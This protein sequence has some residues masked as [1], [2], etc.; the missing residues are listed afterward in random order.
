MGP[1]TLKAAAAVTLIESERENVI[2]L[3][4]ALAVLRAGGVRF[5]ARLRGRY[6]V[7]SGWIAWDSKCRLEIN[8]PGE[9]TQAVEFDGEHPLAGRGW[10]AADLAIE[11]GGAEISLQLDGEIVRRVG[12]GRRRDGTNVAAVGREQVD[13]S[14]SAPLNVIVAVYENLEATVACFEALFAEGSAA[15]KRVIAVDDASPNEAIRGWLSCQAARGMLETIRNDVNLGF[16]ASVNRALALCDQGDALLLNADAFLTPGAIDRLAAVA[17]SAEDIGTVTPFSNNGEFTSF[18]EPNVVNAL[19]D[20]RTQRDIAEAAFAAN[21]TEAVDMPNGVGFCLYVTRACLDRVGAMPELYARGYY[22]DVEFCLRARE[23]GLRSVCATG[24]YV[25]HA[26]AQSFRGEKRALVLRNLAI[27]EGRFPGYTP[28]C[29]AYLAADP[30]WPGARG[31]RRAIAAAGA[32][33]SD[34]RARRRGAPTRARARTRDGPGRR[35]RGSHL[36]H[37]PRGRPGPI[38]RT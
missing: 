38:D 26:G 32:G 19:P 37:D 2:G 3:R 13:G 28:E 7:W 9:P 1:R 24:V 33:N 14:N 15:P 35:G 4:K 22:E 12:S 17:R 16:A 27:V 25:A 23:A 36:R 21:G 8:L 5:S 20:P 18:P 31:N 10:R 6:G 30:L 29:A 11:T 34:D